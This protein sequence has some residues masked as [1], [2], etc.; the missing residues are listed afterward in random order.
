MGRPAAIVHVVT[1]KADDIAGAHLLSRVNRVQ[2]QGRQMPV[3]TPERLRTLM[4]EHNGRPVVLS[5]A[6]VDDGGDD[7]IEHRPN[8]S[9]DGNEE[10]DT[11]VD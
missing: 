6:V 9:S 4:F 1:N 8:R 2:G 7:S 3:E 11:Q 10:I 5:C